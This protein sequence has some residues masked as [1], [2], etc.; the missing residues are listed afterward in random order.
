MLVAEFLDWNASAECDSF[1]WI[2]D[3]EEH[4]HAQWCTFNRQGRTRGDVDDQPSAAGLY[5]KSN[6]KVI[7]HDC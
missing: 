5:Y 1:K 6:L 2:R 3:S 7:S 4:E